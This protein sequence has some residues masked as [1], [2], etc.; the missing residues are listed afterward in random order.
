MGSK[1]ISLRAPVSERL[2]GYQRPDESFS[3][4]VDRV[5]D[6]TRPDWHEFV[7]IL[8]EEDATR[9]KAIVA[10]RRERS[11]RESEAQYDELFGQ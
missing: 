8:S 2:E 4:T 3:D 7:G 11:I 10:E 6:D 5:L 9:A 1:N